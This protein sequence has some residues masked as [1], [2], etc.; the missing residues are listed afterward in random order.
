MSDEIEVKSAEEAVAVDIAKPTPPPETPVNFPKIVRP[1]WDAFYDDER[2]EVWVGVKIR[3]TVK[4]QTSPNGPVQD[5]EVNL[6]ALSLV[7]SLDAA[8]Q[9]ALQFLGRDAQLLNEKSQRQASLKT[10]TAQGFLKRTL[11]GVMD[12]LKK[13]GK[14]LL[15]S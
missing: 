2:N 3:G 5:V 8:K 1:I 9:H 14:V 10:P 12:D 15:P 11:G 6:D 7:T 13:A 4:A